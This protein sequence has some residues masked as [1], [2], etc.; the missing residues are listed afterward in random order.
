MTFPKYTKKKKNQSL[1]PFLCFSRT[2]SV[3][4]PLI[5]GDNRRFA[6]S[7]PFS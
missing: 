1:L 7:L 3:L 4:F 6:F 2:G 5:P